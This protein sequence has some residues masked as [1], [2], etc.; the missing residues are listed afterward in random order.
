MNAREIAIMAPL[1]ILTIGAWLLSEAGARHDVRRREGDDRALSEGHSCAKQRGARRTSSR[2]WR[3][4]RRD[5]PRNLY[6]L[7][8]AALS[9]YAPIFPG[10]VHPCWRLSSSSCG[11][12]TI[13]IR[14]ASR[15]AWRRSSCSSE[16]A[17]LIARHPAATQELFNGA[18]ID[19][20]FARFMKILT[21][22]GIGA[23][24]SFCRSTTCAASGF[25]ASNI[26]S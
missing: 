23:Y 15:S 1:V 26:R 24:P 5:A 13:V 7:S 14:L 19:D 2:D 25:C 21:L 20:S 9:Q 3:N 6:E 22:P 10:T 11:A 8:R 12:P 4:K 16:S 18:F 17:L